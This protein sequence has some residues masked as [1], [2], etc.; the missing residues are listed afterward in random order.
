MREFYNISEIAGLFNLHPD[1]LRYYEEK[2]LLHPVRGANRYRMYGIQDICTLNIIRSLRDL[3]MPVERIGEYL[4][5]RSV[6]ST[7]AL[8][9]E[10][11]ALLTDRMAELECLL[12]QAKERRQRL[13]H[14]TGI[15]V[16]AVEW[17]DLPERPYVAL[18]ED[19]ILDNE[20]DF[21]LKKLEK[22]H[23]DYI[24]IIGSQCMGATLDRESL[25]KGV[26]NHYANVFFLTQPGLPHNGLLPAG[27]YARLYYRG[28]YTLLRENLFLLERSIRAQGLRPAAPPLELYHIDAHD[29]DLEEEFLTEVQW[30]VEQCPA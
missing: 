28:P 15:P 4:S 10:E 3:D 17:S 22:E 7:L 12:Q 30:R 8:I 13:S 26:Y 25:A 27:R 9:G 29:T 18:Q 5:H 19:I 6:D 21:L 14:Y 1:T 16:G 20:I 11:E 23:Q 24:R 2:G